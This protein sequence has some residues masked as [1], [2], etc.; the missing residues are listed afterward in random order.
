MRPQDPE[1]LG[2]RRVASLAPDERGRITL[3]K[4]LKQRRNEGTSFAAYVNEAGQIML[5]PMM[6]VPARERWLYE[7]P[8]AMKALKAG[9]DSAA[10]KPAIS[11]GSFAKYA[12]DD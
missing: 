8:K 3:S 6:E 12:K 7:S 9:L 10:T 1:K 5:D 11:L 4:L 2:F